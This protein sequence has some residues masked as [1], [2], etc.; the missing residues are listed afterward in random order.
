M[1]QE[2]E[3]LCTSIAIIDQG[4]IIAE[5]RP[6]DLIGS[7]AEYSDLENIFLQLTGRELRDN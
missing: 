6:K 4:K 3:K 2:A 5:G 1:M 7:R